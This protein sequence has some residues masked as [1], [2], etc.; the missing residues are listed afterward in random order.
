VVDAKDKSQKSFLVHNGYVS[1]FPVLLG[2]VPVDSPKLEAVLRTLKDPNQ[3]WS[4]YGIR[5]LSKTDPYFGSGENYWKGP[6]WINI[7]YLLLSSL[8]KN[9]INEGPHRQLAKQMYEELRSNVVQNVY[10]VSFL[11]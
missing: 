8:Y 9:Y 10:N 4:S 11:L 3:M 1:L 2:L 5:S 6:I 7:N